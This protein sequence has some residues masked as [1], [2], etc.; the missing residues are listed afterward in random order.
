MSIEAITYH[1]SQE[2]LF[3]SQTDHTGEIS[4]RFAHENITPDEEIPYLPAPNLLPAASIVCT[5]FILDKLMLS[6]ESNAFSIAKQEINTIDDQSEKIHTK[7][8]EALTKTLA[9]ERHQASWSVFAHVT[10]WMGSL[11]GIVAGITLIA[12]G[13]GVVPGVMMIIAGLFAFSLQLMEICQVWNKLIEILPTGDLAKSK[14]IVSWI[15]IGI[16]GL[17]VLVGIVSVLVGGFWSVQDSMKTF[18]Q[19]FNGV[20]IGAEGLASIGIGITSYQFF[21]G[22]ASI[23]EHD[24]SLAVLKHA[25]EDLMDALEEYAHYMERLMEYMAESLHTLKEIFHAEQRAWN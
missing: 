18:M 7:R 12:T 17:S 15:Q 25:R 5:F 20:I 13:V 19:I 21:N 2:T 8:L 9:K 1:D 14:A 11:T 16:V 4:E 24:I 6:S 23:K 10:A 3:V 22:R